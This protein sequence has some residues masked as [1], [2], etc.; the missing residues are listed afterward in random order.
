MPLVTNAE[1]RNQS[2]YGSFAPRA[3][4][5]RFGVHFAAIGDGGDGRFP[6]IDALKT[7]GIPVGD[8]NQSLTYEEYIGPDGKPHDIT[9]PNG[10]KVREMITPI[11]DVLQK[12]RIEGELSEQKM[13]EYSKDR[14]SE[15][16]RI[17]LSGEITERSLGRT[18]IPHDAETREQ[19]EKASSSAPKRRGNP[20]GLAKARAAAAVKRAAKAEPQPA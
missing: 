6:N 16:G 9:L 15:D 20:E 10:T 14:R 18:M 7:V 19:I 17:H 3:D 1:P 4:T 13:A 11:E 8:T 5:R 12:N 2:S